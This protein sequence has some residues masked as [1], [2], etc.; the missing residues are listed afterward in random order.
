[1]CASR[2]YKWKMMFE[3]KGFLSFK[4]LLNSFNNDYDNVNLNAAFTNMINTIYIDQN[5][6]KA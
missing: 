3:N 6:M 4:A 2:N 5:Q 1:M